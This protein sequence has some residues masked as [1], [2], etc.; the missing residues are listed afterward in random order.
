MKMHPHRSGRLGL[1]LLTTLL[2]GTTIRLQAGPPFRTDDPEPVALGHAEVY[3]SALG[4]RTAEA[5]ILAAPLLEF[6]Y[7]ALPDL[8]L[9][10]VVPLAQVKPAGEPWARG[11]GDT[12]FGMKYRFVQ[13]T[14][15]LPQVGLFPMVVVPTGKTERG[16]G[17][18]HTAVYLP[19]WLQKSFGKWTTYGGYG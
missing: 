19:I 16:L 1:A 14:D 15:V 11:C 4:A 7:G 12:E 9:H 17:S 6:N 3:L 8:Q 5:Q 13:E 10:L 18:G 2:L